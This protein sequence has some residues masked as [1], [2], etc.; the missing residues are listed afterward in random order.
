LALK[1][2][3]AA[4]QRARSIDAGHVSSSW[5]TEQRADRSTNNY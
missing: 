4:R 3:V 1:A 2:L 5:L